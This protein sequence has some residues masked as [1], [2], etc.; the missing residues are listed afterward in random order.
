MGHFS[1]KKKDLQEKPFIENSEILSIDFK[2]S[3][4]YFTKSV[5]EKI[6]KLKPKWLKESH[7]GKQFVLCHNGKIILTGY[8]INSWSSYWSN[9]YQIYYHSLPEKKITDSLKN[10]RYTFSNSINFEENNLKKNID[11]YNAFRN[12]AIN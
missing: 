4:I 3:E 2:K 9:T 7:F 6:S 1:A 8:F 5:A 10:V 12:R 11:L